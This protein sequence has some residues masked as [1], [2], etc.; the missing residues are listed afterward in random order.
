MPRKFSLRSQF[1][2]EGVFWPAGSRNQSFAGRLVASA[3]GIEL[4]AA[5]ITG[6][7]TFFAHQEPA[8]PGVMHGRT[9]LGD[10]TLIDVH[11]I[12]GPQQLDGATS[13]VLSI[14]RFRVSL[15]IVGMHLDDPA[16]PLRGSVECTYSGLSN[17]LRPTSRVTPTE[18]GIS[19][20]YS[21]KSRT[22]VDFCVRANK[23]RIAL[24]V[25]SDVHL[26][27]WHH[28]AVNRPRIKIE[29]VELA[30]IE[31]LYDDASRLEDF[32]S[33]FLGVSVRLLTVRF[34]SSDNREGW[35]V[36][37]QRGRIDKYDLE[38]S[39]GSESSQLAAAIT[40]WFS[41]TENLRPLQN[42]VYGTVRDTSM[43]VETEFLS[44]AQALESFHRLTDSASLVDSSTF[45]GIR[46][47]INE[48]IEAVC[49]FPALVTKLEESVQF[50]NEPGF[51]NRINGLLGRLKPEHVQ[52]LL[53]DPIEF[54]QTLRQTRNFLTHL[55][56]RGQTKVLRSAGDF[57][58]FN[59]KLH[60]LLRFLML[61]NVGFSEDAVFKAI[62]YQSTRWT[63]L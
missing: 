25:G 52:I 47:K 49:H 19:L 3:K 31:R 39:F 26:R 37:P 54:E 5:K 57:F 45:E 22:L 18:E 32:L 59:Q 1:E 53:G 40:A 51:R 56:I 11:A 43:F 13:E 38:A 48:V 35:F 6:P 4:S 34:S 2:A 8:S 42:F 36:R 61:M 41:A 16:A 55:G 50:A 14:R 24:S 46:T 63:L 9:I 23:T 27:A 62:R 12:N 33:L 28:T 17:W 60:A 29:P 7:E 10:C 58:L 20:N 15:C 44:L 21:L 30:S